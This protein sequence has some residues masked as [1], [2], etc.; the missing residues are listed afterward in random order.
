LTLRLSVLPERLAVSRLAPTEPIPDWAASPGFSSVTRTRDELSIVC[1][2]AAVP[3]AVRSERGWRALVVAG[4]LDFGLV[5]VIAALA[6]PL[7]RAGLPIFVVSTFDS[8][9]L[10]VKEARLAEAI[11]V[12]ESAGHGVSALAV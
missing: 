10:L 5:G 8:D 6:E 2:E 11:A 7:A 1:A 3:A 4:P 9:C 12:L